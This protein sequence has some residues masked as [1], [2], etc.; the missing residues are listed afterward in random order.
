MATTHTISGLTNAVEA[1]RGELIT[2]SSLGAES[3]KKGFDIYPN[4]VGKT[5]IPSLDTTVEF[6]DGAVCSFSPNGSDVWGEVALDPKILKVDKS[7]CFRAMY[8]KAEA[9]D[10]KVAIGLEEAPYEDEFINSQLGAIDEALDVAIWSGNTAAGMTGITQQ[11]SG[12]VSAATGET[13]IATVDNIYN[14]IPAKAFKAGRDGK[15]RMYM[16][17]STLQSYISAL[18]AQCCGKVGLIDAAVDEL[19]MPGDSRVILTPVV[20]LENLGYIVAAPNGSLAY[21]TGNPED[22][23]NIFRFK[24][25]EKDDSFFLKVAFA[26]ATAVKMPFYTVYAQI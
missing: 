26:A 1:R 2:K 19:A 3:L 14:A 20:G 15:V 24:Q 4:L 9:W 22:A 6:Q 23:Q 5:V 8:G 10:A 11:L 21:G 12:A 17:H 7:W 16:S 18:N 13:I 25:D